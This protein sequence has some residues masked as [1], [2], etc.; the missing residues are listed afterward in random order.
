MWVPRVVLK[1]P[2][3]P[4]LTEP[5]IYGDRVVGRDGVAGASAMRGS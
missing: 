1:L 4:T 2:A 3:A 5:L